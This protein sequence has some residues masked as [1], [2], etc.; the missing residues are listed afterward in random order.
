M[1]MDD[2]LV[3]YVVGECFIHL[4][5]EEVEEKLQ[6]CEG[7]RWGACKL[8]SVPTSF[9]CVFQSLPALIAWRAAIHDPGEG[10]GLLHPGGRRRCGHEAAPPAAAW[11][12][13]RGGQAGRAACR[14]RSRYDTP[15]GA[16][17]SL[18]SVPLW[19]AVG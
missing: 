12:G 16:A 6:Q 4:P 10:A 14:I 3:P 19:Q 7:H 11:V 18:A 17:A 5:K 8:S 15:C 2:E 9:A 13:R 1:L